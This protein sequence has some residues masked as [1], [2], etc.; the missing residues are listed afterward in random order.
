[1]TV[2]R[3]LEQAASQGL[4]CRDGSG[5]KREPYRYWYWLREREEQWRQSPEGR[6]MLEE[7]QQKREIMELILEANRRALEADRDANRPFPQAPEGRL[8]EESRP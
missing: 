3:W 1:M 5:R 7:E 8:D 2:W 6:R 4:V